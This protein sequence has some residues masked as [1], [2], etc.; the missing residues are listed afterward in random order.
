MVLWR[1]RMITVTTALHVI[2]TLENRSFMMADR[3][4]IVAC[5]Q[6]SVWR[7]WQELQ[8]LAGALVLQMDGMTMSF[9]YF[10]RTKLQC[11]GF[12]ATHWHYLCNEIKSFRCFHGGCTSLM[13]SATVAA[14][15]PLFP[16]ALLSVITPFC[17]WEGTNSHRV[18]VSTTNKL[19]L[20]VA[21]R[22]LPWTHRQWQLRIAMC[23]KATEKS[24]GRELQGLLW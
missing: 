15:N 10:G 13:D 3:N 4:G 18:T 16:T 17:G 8:I 1:L 14:S 6:L 11:T 5:F 2:A 22:W 7:C 12:W 23:L 21:A 9:Q 24:C 19:T 20:D